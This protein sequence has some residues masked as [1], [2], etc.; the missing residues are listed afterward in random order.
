MDES[1]LLDLLECPV[2]L[3]RLDASAKVLPCQHTFCKRCLLG[4]VSSR[5]E[6]RC[7]ECRTLVDCGVDELPSNILLVRLLDGIKQRPRKPGTGAGTGSTTALRVPVNTAANCGSKDPQSSQAGQ[8]QRVQ[9]RSPPVR[10]RLMRSCSPVAGVPR[11]ALNA[12]APSGLEPSGATE[13]GRGVA[14]GPPCAD[15]LPRRNPDD[16]APLE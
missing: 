13:P 6:L 16:P 4:I 8:Q 5:N 2:C 15:P 7:P 9:A 14:H 11:A 10:E 3:E 12:P 1:A